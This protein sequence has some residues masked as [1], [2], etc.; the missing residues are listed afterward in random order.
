MIEGPHIDDEFLLQELPQQCSQYELPALQLF[1]PNRWL[2]H[3]DIV[4][5]GHQT[6]EV[7]HCPGHTPGH[8]AFFHRAA[9]LLAVGDILFRGTIGATSMPYGDRRQLIASI[10]ERL[11]PLGDNVR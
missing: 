7:V 9:K 4:T 3:G 6:V 1:T 2:L 11:F 10:R 8:V 5:F